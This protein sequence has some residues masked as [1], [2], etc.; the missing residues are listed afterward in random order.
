MTGSGRRRQGAGNA[1]IEAGNGLTTRS[2]AARGAVAQLGERLNG[3]QEVVGSIPIGST[4]LA[5]RASERFVSGWGALSGADLLARL[6][7]RDADV[8]AFVA[9][10]DAPGDGPLLAVKDNVDV[11]GMRTAAGIG[12][13]RS[14]RPAATDAP[15]VA[16]WRSAGGAVLGK[17]NMHEGAL[18]VT[19]DNAVF[20]RTANPVVPGAVPGGSSGGSAAAV[21]AGLVRFALGTDTMGSV[22]I[23]ASYCGIV[24]FK[25]S[26]GVLPTAGVVPLSWSLDHVGILAGTIAD[27]AFAFA[28]L[29]GATPAPAPEARF[30]VPRQLDE[31]DLEPSVAAAFAAALRR[32]AAAGARI[33]RAPLDGWRPAALGRDALI[34]AEVEGAVVFADLLGDPA[35][36]ITPAFRALLDYGRRLAAPR[37]ATAL[38]TCREVGGTLDRQLQPFAAWLLPTTPQ[39]AFPDGAP[40]PPSVADLTVPAN[41]GG[42]PAL[43][44]PLPGTAKPVGLQLVAAAGRDANLLATAAAVAAMLD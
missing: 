25:P 7:E 27:I 28:R 21:A 23:P 36:D 5:K 26:F 34:V 15:V 16:R 35:S 44:L 10:A 14:R 20:G 31:Y 9:W 12:A 40:T 1:C 33:E 3:I 18:G 41:A 39:T 2:L 42:L 38:R 24:G 19:T 32:L 17:T 22:R 6:R 8:G 30:L 37:Y 43:S 4:T 29:T 11:E 13:W